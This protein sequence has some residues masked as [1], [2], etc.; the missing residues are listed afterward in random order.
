MSCRN[1]DE[2]GNGNTSC[3]DGSKCK[4]RGGGDDDYSYDEEEEEEEY[5]EEN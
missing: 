1:G 4:E 3:S 2:C 5:L